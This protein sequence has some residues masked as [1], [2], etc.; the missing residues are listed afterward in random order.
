MLR[1]V[2]D[3]LRTL[4]DLGFEGGSETIAVALKKPKY[5][6]LIDIQQTFRS[7]RTSAAS[8]AR[9]AAKVGNERCQCSTP[10]EPGVT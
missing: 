1:E 5:G 9:R 2:R 8:G 3:E 6:E 7:S 4:G 10:A